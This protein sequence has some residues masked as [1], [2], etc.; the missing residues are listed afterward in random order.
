MNAQEV[1]EGAAALLGGLMYAA[2]NILSSGELAQNQ[3]DLRRARRAES[4]LR[5]QLDSCLERERES[6][7][8]ADRLQSE[9]SRTKLRQG[10]ETM[11]EMVRDMHERGREPK[12]GEPG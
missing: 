7:E 12:T 1:K 11:L 2:A 4:S 8:R 6:R 5:T 10:H 9:L 3:S